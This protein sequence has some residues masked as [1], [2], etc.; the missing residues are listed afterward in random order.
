VGVAGSLL[1]RG[2]LLAGPWSRANACPSWPPPPPPK[3]LRK[4]AGLPPRVGAGGD[5]GRAVLARGSVAQALLVPVAEMAE[6][7]RS[8]SVFGARGRCARPHAL[9]S[10]GTLPACPRSCLHPYP[11]PPT[12]PPTHPPARPPMRPAGRQQQAALAAGPFPKGRSHPAALPYEPFALSP[13]EA[14]RLVTQR[15]LLLVGRDKMVLQGRLM[16]V[17][18]LRAGSGPPSGEPTPTFNRMSVPPGVCPAPLS[19]VSML[20]AHP[21]APSTPPGH[22]HRPHPRQPLLQAR[23]EPR[24][25]EKPPRRSLPNPHVFKH[26]KCTNQEGPLVKL[27]L[28][29]GTRRVGAAGR[30][31]ACARRPDAV[32]P[33][34]LYHLFS[35]PSPSLPQGGFVQVAIVIATRS[36]W[37]KHRDARFVTR[38]CP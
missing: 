17:R 32:H 9:C 38:N 20:T 29:W 26:G 3:D 33:L 23:D 4:R 5:R 24:G 22:R 11:T 28:G 19:L 10:S 21:C 34:T 25:R 36:V 15:Q 8:E 14:L 13:F 27:S 6:R 37:F 1:I 12:H 7:F 31:R 30:A 2:E 35:Y 18:A 16:Q